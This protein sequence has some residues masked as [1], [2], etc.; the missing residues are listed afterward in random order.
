[1]P[2]GLVITLPFFPLIPA[3]AGAATTDFVSK[4]DYRF[5]GVA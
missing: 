5:L 3:F 1:L 2:L 4:S